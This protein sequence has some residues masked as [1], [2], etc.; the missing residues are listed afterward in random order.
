MLNHCIPQYSPC[1]CSQVWRDILQMGKPTKD[2][3]IVLR[4]EETENVLE[5]VFSSMA[6]IEPKD[7]LAT[8]E[9]YMEA[10][11][12]VD[13]Y[14]LP[15]ALACKFVSQTS[16]CLRSLNGVYDQPTLD[17]A[18][19][20]LVW[21]SQTR[22]RHLLLEALK[23]IDQFRRATAV[24]RYS[25]RHLWVYKNFDRWSYKVSQQLGPA[26]YWM[27]ARVT[28]SSEQMTR[29][30]WD[31]PEYWRHIIANLPEFPDTN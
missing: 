4:L 27:L 29:D 11:K 10:F 22:E 5:I 16:K 14:A 26:G 15:S 23:Y 8:I 28:A 31:H 3:P 2:E 30:P 12:L 7:S 18:I 13:K 21:A 6:S 9:L 20:A 25:W 17:I 24:K 19:R 1:N